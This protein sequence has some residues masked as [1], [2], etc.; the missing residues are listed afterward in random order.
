V[1]ARTF[2]ADAGAALWRTAVGNSPGRPASQTG[3]S[4]S[5]GKKTKKILSGLI[6]PLG[7]SCKG[8]ARTDLQSMEGF[9][10]D[11]AACCL[12]RG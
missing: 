12:E 8:G 5:K 11:A 1:Q 9:R 4:T 10:V 3:V 6:F 2:G 7:S